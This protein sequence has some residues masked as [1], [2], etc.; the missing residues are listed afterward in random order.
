MGV[1]FQLEGQ[2][3]KALNGGPQ[4]KFTPA[5]SLFV[6]CES[7]AEV[8]E[9]WQKLLSGGG[10]P[11]HCGWLTDKYGLSWQIIPTVLGDLLGSAIANVLGTF[12]LGLLARKRLQIER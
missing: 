11:S 1:S 6:N 12:P 10:K 3:F 2:E 4:F 5:I 9:L 8:D 7:Q